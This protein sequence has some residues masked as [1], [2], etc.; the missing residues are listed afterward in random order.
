M[1]TIGLLHP[2][3]MGAVLGSVLLEPVL[4]VSAGRSPGSYRRAESAGLVE[5][6]SLD[7]LAGSVDVVLSVCPPE[8]A[9]ELAQSVARAGFSG[10]YVDA[11]AVSPAT[12]RQIGTRF[13]HFVD[14][15]IVGPPPTEPGLTRLYLSGDRA[16]EV[17]ALFDGTA[18]EAR[19][20]N[21]EPGAASAVK[22]C[23][24]SWTKGT[25]ALLLAIRALAEAEG[26]SDALLAEWETSMPELVTRSES[27]AA[28][29]GPKAWRFEGEMHEI[30]AT[31]RD[32][33]LPGEFHA[34]AAEIYRRLASL[35][36]HDRPTLT[37]ALALILES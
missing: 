24:A 5:V 27:V 28:A 36:E 34:G 19:V 16:G 23:F 8:S 20:V 4:W 11:N 13:D 15:G 29:V 35:K 17:R 31:F 33:H 37:E 22:M 26:V 7:A 32:D 18:V 21:D 3:A 10:L 2:G 1:T 14:G 6:E 25:S 12:A 9:D 30:S